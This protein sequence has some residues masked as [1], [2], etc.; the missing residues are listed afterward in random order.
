MIEERVAYGDHPLQQVLLCLPEDG[1]EGA[2]LVVMFPGGGWRSGDPDRF[3][4][5]AEPLVGHGLPVALV[6]YRAVPEHVFP[7][8]RDD[9]LDGFA[10]ALAAGAE[11][12]LRP[13]GAVLGGQSAGAHLAALV[14]YD[15]GAREERGIG[16][17]AIGGLL[18]ISGPLDLRVRG[19]RELDNLVSDLVGHGPPWDEA[20]P[21]RF[22]RGDE[23]W[24]V[25]CLHGGRDPLVPLGS[26]AAFVARFEES[27]P[28]LA[29]LLV[30]PEAEHSSLLTMLAQG[31]TP[32]A[33]TMLEWIEALSDVS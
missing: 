32:L 17:E 12:G 11:R 29:R 4:F 24:P 31:T 20:D 28:G 2:R 14:A 30:E 3:R 21:A 8:Q 27:S 25:L 15:R 7:A 18:S 5:F 23:L 16:E 22:V 9:A 13:D 19:G 10:A 6:G 26:A 33:G 1:A